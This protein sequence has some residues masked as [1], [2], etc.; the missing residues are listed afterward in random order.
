MPGGG[1]STQ[2]LTRR[3]GTEA[4]PERAAVVAPG[5]RGGLGRRQ[6]AGGSRQP[7]VE[8]PGPA[9]FGSFAL[10]CHQDHGSTSLKGSCCGQ[11][12]VFVG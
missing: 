2:P 1:S 4:G 8:D 9:A 12:F 7:S 5:D 6:G 11:V 3:Q 10:L